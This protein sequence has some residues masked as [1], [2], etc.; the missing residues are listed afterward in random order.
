MMKMKRVACLAIAATVA[1]ATPALAKKK[2]KSSGGQAYSGI[3]CEQGAQNIF[4]PAASLPAK[5]RR[6]IRKGQKARVNV[7][8]IGP[9]NCRAY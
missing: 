8:G 9:L 5:Y 4:I 3:Y 7:A 6:S 2:K 1:I